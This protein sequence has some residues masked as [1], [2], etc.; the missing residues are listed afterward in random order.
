MKLTPS[1]L[2]DFAM[3][4]TV[5]WCSRNPASV[6]AFFAPDASLAVNGAPAV[7]RSAITQVARGFMTAFPGMVLTMT[8][9]VISGG[10]IEY[11]WTLDGTN[12]GPGGTGKRVRISGFEE[13][14]IGADGLI[15]ESQGHFDEALY[16]HQLQFGFDESQ[17]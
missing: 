1:E 2:R 15:A 4:Y 11:H 12:T 8:D 17:P 5:A 6:G 9:V 13:W 16:Q 7:G 10:Q 3:R 14:K